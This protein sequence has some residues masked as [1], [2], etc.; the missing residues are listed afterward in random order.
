M[1]HH[2]QSD[3]QLIKRLIKRPYP[4]TKKSP[5]AEALPGFFVGSLID[6]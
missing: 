2:R 6:P 4:Q 5:A 3:R 1:A